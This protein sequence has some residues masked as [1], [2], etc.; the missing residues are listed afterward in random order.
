MLTN[1]EI[2]KLVY[3]LLDARKKLLWLI[4]QTPI[5]EAQ[6]EFI[7]GGKKLLKQVNECLK[8]FNVELPQ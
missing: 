1:S 8:A 5:N 3:S 6:S 7:E 2:N 4:S